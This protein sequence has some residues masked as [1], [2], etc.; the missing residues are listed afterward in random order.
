MS[1]KKVKNKESWFK[2]V[3]EEF[4][5]VRWPSKKDMIKYTNA[6]LVFII[7]FG[8]FFYLIELAVYF[9]KAA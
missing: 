7:F 5:K 6:T 4:K 2:G 8:I 3:K 9:I 1:E